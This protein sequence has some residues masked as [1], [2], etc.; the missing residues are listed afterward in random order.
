[1]KHGLGGIKLR[2]G[3]KHTTGIACEENDVA[4][5]AVRLARYLGV[6]NIFDW[7]G[8]SGILRQGGIVVIN[9]SSFWIEYNVLQN[10]AKLNCVEN[11]WLLLS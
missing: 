1:M 8:A 5:M 11:I 4:G 2:D 3:R 6:M 9:K 7:I 10:R